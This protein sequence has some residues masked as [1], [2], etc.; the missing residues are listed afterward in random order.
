M[1]AKRAKLDEIFAEIFQD[2]QNSSNT[3]NIHNHLRVWFKILL[4]YVHH[5]PSTNSSDYI[6]T[7]QKYMLFYIY[8]GSKMNLPS[9]L[10]K[11]LREI[12][13]KTRNGTPKPRKWISLG[14][15]ISYVL[16]ESKLVLTLIDVGLTKEV[17]IDIRKTFK[18]K[19]LK[20]ISLITDVPDPSESLK[21]N[22][23]VSR[24]IH[25]DDYP[26]LIV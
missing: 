6:N 1:L 5:R 11:Y 21:R 23:V 17:D 26:L 19:N 3:K 7:N 4:G 9:I 24:R 2:G 20:N 15:L 8:S 10:F 16:F 12:I 25:I 22:F 14:R 13:K 18:G